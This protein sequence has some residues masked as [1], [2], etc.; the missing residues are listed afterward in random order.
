MIKKVLGAMLILLAFVG[1]WMFFYLPHYWQVNLFE[2]W[3]GFPFFFTSAMVCLT[4]FV[5]GIY[6]FIYYYD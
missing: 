3:W 4:L 2:V 1:M 5:I 6:I